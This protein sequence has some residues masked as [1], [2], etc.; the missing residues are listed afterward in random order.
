MLSAWPAA[1]QRIGSA[2][3]GTQAECTSGRLRVQGLI[4]RVYARVRGPY[5]AYIRELRTRGTFCF[6]HINKCGG[7]SVERALGLP[8]MHDTA[9]ERIEKIGQARW[10]ACHTFTIVRNPYDKVLSHYRYRVKTNQTGMGET[11]IPL[12]EWIARAYGEKDPKYHDRPRFFAP[13][14]HWITDETGKII[15]DQICKLET[16]E[17]DWKAVKQKTGITVDLPRENTTRAS[18]ADELDAASLDIIEEQ[19]AKDFETFGYPLRSR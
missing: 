15:V 11:D 4:D 10:D 5:R 1:V 18:R 9:L 14:L 7:T 19:F 12:N 8:L 2:G 17:E 6:I 13:C 3:G 16:I